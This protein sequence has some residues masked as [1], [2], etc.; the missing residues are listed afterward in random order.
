MCDSGF[1]GTEGKAAV[2]DCVRLSHFYLLRLFSATSPLCTL[3]N[4]QHQDGAKL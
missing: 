3:A 4:L 1:G 2:G